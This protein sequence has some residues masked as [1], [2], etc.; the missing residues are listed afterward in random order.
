MMKPPLE[1]K[2]ESTNIGNV[3][4]LIQ[5]VT[6]TDE[7]LKKHITGCLLTGLQ[8]SKTMQNDLLQCIAD[9]VQGKIVDEVQVFSIDNS[10]LVAF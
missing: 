4:A 2:E 6:R 3:K 8:I 7:D 10:L 9:F 5:L 1:Y